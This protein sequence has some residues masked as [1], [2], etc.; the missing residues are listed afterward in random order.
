MFA[1]ISTMI[2]PIA[3]AAIGTAANIYG[4][5][6]A[7]K[8]AKKAEDYNRQRMNDVGSWFNKEYYGNYL[9]TDA[10]RSALGTVSRQ[11]KES[12]K[13][14][15]NQAA[16][17]GATPEAVIAQTG[18]TNNVYADAVN[19]LVSQGD[20]RRNRAMYQYQGLM[21]PLQANEANILAGKANQ[22]NTFGK[23]VSSA[24]GNIISAWANGAFDKK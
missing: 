9:N 7:N 20:E 3:T 23:N 21:Q 14:V 15:Q 17:G 22:W 18:K 11:L 4:Q 12:N 6:Q 8:A 24:G 1:K 2:L 5:F 13:V 10:A 16:A 19:T